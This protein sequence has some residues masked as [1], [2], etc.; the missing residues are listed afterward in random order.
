MTTAH[1]PEPAEVQVER[2][3]SPTWIVRLAMGLIGIVLV[4]GAIVAYRMHWGAGGDLGAA[5]PW[6]MVLAVLLGAGA[7]IESITR[8]VWITL[9]AGIFAVLVSYVIT[10]TYVVNLDAS[11]HAVFVVDRYTGETHYCTATDCR[12]VSAGVGGATIQELR[13]KLH[14]HKP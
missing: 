8:S 5:L 3:R 12:T 11:T 10:G 9:L 7:V 2:D 6:I 13:D 1:Q 4:A 14:A